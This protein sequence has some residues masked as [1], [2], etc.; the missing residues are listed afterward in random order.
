MSHR[1]LSNFHRDS[2]MNYILTKT[3]S[4]KKV[5]FQLCMPSDKEV[6]FYTIH[7]IG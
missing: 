6:G 3:H 2:D 5:L 1:R 7:L 4:Q